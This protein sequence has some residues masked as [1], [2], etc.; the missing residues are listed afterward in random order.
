[1]IKLDKE[2]QELFDSTERGEWH[3]VPDLEQEI[4]E[5]KKI[6][7]ATFKK[8]ERMN[9]RI[10]P[11]DL[12]ALKIEALGEGMPYQTLVSSII[13]KYLSGR[14]VAKKA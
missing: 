3:S 2:E 9:I 4:Q 14:L 10:S 13:H 7:G 8:T 5:A 11:K 12:N 1:M 6:A